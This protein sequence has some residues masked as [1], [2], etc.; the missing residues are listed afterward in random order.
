MEGNILTDLNGRL[1]NC[2]RTNLDEALETK[3]VR[4]WRKNTMS[5]LCY[6]YFTTSRDQ[7]LNF[8]LDREAGCL[9]NPNK[10]YHVYV[11]DDCRDT[12]EYK[13]NIKLSREL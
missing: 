1:M 3:K 2:F 10:S 6:R 11:D 12:H 4:L 7:Q 9:D 8:L 5:S 13:T